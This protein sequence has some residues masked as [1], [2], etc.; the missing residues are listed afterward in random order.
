M[1]KNPKLF[2][3]TL[4]YVFL[5]FVSTATFCGNG[6]VGNKLC[7]N[8]SHCCSKFGHCGL[9]EPWC[10]LNCVGGACWALKSTSTS[11]TTTSSSTSASVTSATST[12]VIS[13]TSATVT[14]STSTPMASTT[15]IKPSAAASPFIFSPYKDITINYDWNNGLIRSK[16]TGAIKE[17]LQVF[18]SKL[19]TLTFAFASGECG[20]EL[21]AGITPSQVQINI[22]KFVNADKK[23]IISTGGAAGVFTCETDA[24]FLKFIQTYYSANMVG[25]DFDIEGGLT[26][27]QIK[28]LIQRTKY[29]Q[30][31][32][33]NLRFSF[34][35]ATLGGNSLNSL[36]YLG[37]LVVTEIKASGLSNYYINLMTMD[38][39]T[40]SNSVC[41]L[42]VNQKCDMGLSAIQAVKNLNQYYSIP[43]SKI[44]V[45]PMIGM[46]DVTDEIFSLSD[47]KVITK[48]VKDN[49]LAGL[50]FWSFDRDTDCNLNYASP[51]CNSFGQG[52]TL[53]FTNAFLAELDAP[54]S[55]SSTIINSSGT[56]SAA[57][58]TSTTTTVTTT[59]SSSTSKTTSSSTQT[60]I[61]GVSAQHPGTSCG[62]NGKGTLLQISDSIQICSPPVHCN[63]ETCPPQLG[64]CVDNVCIY[65]PGYKGLKTLPQAWATYYCDLLGGGCHGVTQSE[66]PEITAKKIA[67]ARKLPL[68]AEKVGGKCVGIAAS[69]PMVVGNSQLATDSNGDFLKYW[70]LGFSEASDVC[71]SLSG[72]GGD[73]VVALTDRCGGYCKCGASGYQECGPCVED[74]SLSPNGACVG[75]LPL[76]GFNTCIGNNCGVPVQQNCDWCASNNHP[77]FDVDTDTF[78]YLCGEASSAGS[79]QITKVVPIP[80]NGLTGVVWP[81]SE[82]S[83]G[84]GG[85]VPCSG[86]SFDCSGSS[87]DSINQ[88]LIPNTNCCCYWGLSPNNGVCV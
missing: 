40:A 23:Y 9:A 51:V 3:A 50:H 86:K 52:G 30:T 70:G 75:A 6:N 5:E 4:L 8:S 28:S 81:P 13:S 10:G 29:A 33:P 68:C 2:T 32:Y 21:W 14:T 7:P 34:T 39:G 26:Q 44:E 19:D 80:C 84:G 49:N 64:T 12:T 31:L 43:Y 37:N 17:I 67:N 55:A 46:N 18:P 66:F 27:N 65:K 71:Y 47:V 62:F 88:P 82:S 73:V 69:S 85:S 76:L 20:S 57:S 15:S 54:I 60:P 58:S 24:G 42:N 87:P 45:T 79:C 63:P 78:N 1:R 16:V 61:S 41:A 77:H 56:S 53:G 35:I 48:F 59:S 74:S 72:P 25:I 38:Y 22:N 83:G 11:M 36:N